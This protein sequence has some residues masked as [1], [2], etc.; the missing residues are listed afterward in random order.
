MSSQRPPSTTARTSSQPGRRAPSPGAAGV[1]ASE[2]AR[3]ELA[4]PAMRLQILSTE[5]WSLLASRGLA[6]SDSFSRTG[7]FLSTL[8]FAVVALALVAQATEFGDGFRL[9]SL[10]VLPVV[11]FL[12]IG[13]LLHL[14]T[15]N[16]Q[17]LMCVVG[18]NRVRAMYVELA[19]DLEDVFV[20][21]T[22]DD[23]AGIM[24]TMALVPGR[25]NAVNHFAATPVQ[26]AV[27]DAVLVAAIVALV[28]IQ[29]GGSE[30]VAL[31]A[32][33]IGFVGALVLL[34][35]Y[36]QRTLRA[37]NRSHHPRYRSTHEAREHR[38]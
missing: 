1:P 24:K 11:L 22:G 18:L 30:M 16:Y 23:W 13:T 2:Q 31:A 27:L 32:G 36:S 26:V 35:W 15:T 17:E 25:S 9:F 28:V 7:M 38:A 12:G 29:A 37:A 21:G 5:H 10:A 4:T 3:V 6:W 34:V 8:S 14:D 20:A 19:P 33:A